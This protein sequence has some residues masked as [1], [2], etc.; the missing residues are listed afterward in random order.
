MRVEAKTVVTNR[1]VKQLAMGRRP[2]FSVI[3]SL[4]DLMV[5]APGGSE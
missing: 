4:S 2:H 5:G 1:T 3:M